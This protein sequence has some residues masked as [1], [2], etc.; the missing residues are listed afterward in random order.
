MKQRTLITVLGTGLALAAL[1]GDAAPAKAKAH[2]AID[3][4]SAYVFRGATLNDGSVLQ[5]SLEVTGLPI[6]IGTWGNFDINDFDGRRTGNQFSEI[7]LYGSYSTTIDKVDLTAGYT[8][9]VYPNTVEYVYP[10]TVARE[11]DREARLTAGLPLALDPKM[12]VFYM[13]DGPNQSDLYVQ[14]EASHTKKISALTSLEFFATAGYQSD[15]ETLDFSGLPLDAAGK[16]IGAGTAVKG[17]SGLA[18]YT[19]GVKGTYQKLTAGVTYIGR[20]DD[21]VLPDD[22]YDVNVVFTVGLATDF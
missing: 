1:R 12:T 15:D 19:A 18:N 4:A 5:P 13:L 16:P 2:A 22:V 17:E 8:E 14:A 21:K 10:D 7:D 11:A 6:T 9:Y 20:F 3:Y